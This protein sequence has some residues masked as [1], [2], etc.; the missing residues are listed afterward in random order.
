MRYAMARHAVTGYDLEARAVPAGSLEII[1]RWSTATTPGPRQRRER[2]A[3]RVV[4]S[5]HPGAVTDGDQHSRISGGGL[6]AMYQGEESSLRKI[7]DL[8]PN[9]PA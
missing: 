3:L 9:L 4:V 2:Q 6:F 1:S 8:M 5:R 7:E